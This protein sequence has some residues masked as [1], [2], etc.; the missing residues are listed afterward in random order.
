MPVDSNGIE[1]CVHLVTLVAGSPEYNNVESEFNK[2]MVKGSNYK[3]IVS[4]QR[5]QNPVLHH[6][7]MVRKKEMDK[8]NRSSCQNE[9]WLFHGT[10]SDTL[11]HINA[12]GF[13]RSF[14]GKSGMFA[15]ISY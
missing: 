1:K 2:T 4:I 7:Y 9:R 13:N 5:I 6:Q 10:T 8:R 11:A 15:V 14:A 12:E 3:Q